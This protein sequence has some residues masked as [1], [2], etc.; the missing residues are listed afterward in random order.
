MLF[1]EKEQTEII[2]GKEK[3]CPGEH[4]ISAVQFEGEKATGKVLNYAEA[5]FKIKQN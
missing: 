4:V 5:K 1:K 3:L 2:I